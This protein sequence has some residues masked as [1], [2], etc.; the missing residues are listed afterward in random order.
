M[1]KIIMKFNLYLI[2]FIQTHNNINAYLI[3]NY[4]ATTIARIL[5]YKCN[6]WKTPPQR[7]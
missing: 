1:K 4:Q 2:W 5:Y 6:G 7:V 3:L